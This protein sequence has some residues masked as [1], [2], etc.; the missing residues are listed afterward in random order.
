[1]YTR[2]FL[3]F[4]DLFKIL[5]VNHRIQHGILF[6]NL[7]TLPAYE[8]SCTTLGFKFQY[9]KKAASHNICKRVHCRSII[10]TGFL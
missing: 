2:C 1:M 5:R 6:G 4:K 10:M 9:Y 8:Y 3:K 7:H